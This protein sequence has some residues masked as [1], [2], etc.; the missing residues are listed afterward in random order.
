MT[1]IPKPKYHIIVYIRCIPHTQIKLN[2]ERREIR[3]TNLRKM[4]TCGKGKLRYSIIFSTAL[5]LM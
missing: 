4:V 3:G 1:H 2:R 5:D